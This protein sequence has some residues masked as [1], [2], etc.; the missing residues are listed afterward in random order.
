MKLKPQFEKD[1]KCQYCGKLGK[2]KH[3]NV[4]HEKYCDKNPNKVECTG[5]KVSDATKQKISSTSKLSGKSG[6]YRKGAGY[7]KRDGI[8][9]IFVIVLGNW[10]M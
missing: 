10:L 2:Y 9:D 8:K 6:G 7:G 1:G 5:H 4:L 3:S